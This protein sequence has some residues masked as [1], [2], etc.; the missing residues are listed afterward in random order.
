MNET[1]QYENAYLDALKGINELIV[2]YEVSTSHKAVA[3]LNNFKTWLY[4][5]NETITAQ[6]NNNN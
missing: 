5:L 1:T 6:L 2:T 3:K 4:A